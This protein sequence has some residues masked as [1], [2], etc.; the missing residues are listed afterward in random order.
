MHTIVWVEG[1]CNVFLATVRL[2]FLE[3]HAIG[4]ESFA[5]TGQIIDREADVAKALRILISIVV[6][7]TVLFLGPC[8]RL[9]YSFGGEADFV[10]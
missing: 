10:P 3:L 9:D 7:L 2:L 8:T 4:L 6:D 5:S 1:E